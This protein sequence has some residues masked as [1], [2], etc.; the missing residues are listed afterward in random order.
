MANPKTISVQQLSGAV[1]KAAAS[2]KV[3]AGTSGPYA[4]INPA[5]ICGLIYYGPDVEFDGASTLANTIAASASEHLGQVTGIVQTSAGVGAGAGAVG[6]L[7]PKYILC[8]F[9][10][11]PDAHVLY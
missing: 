10:P 5:V 9:K 8:G 3:P 2:V 6:N 11:G 4:Y 1:K 7:A